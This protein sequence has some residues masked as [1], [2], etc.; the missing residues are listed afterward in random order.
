MQ[1]IH[2]LHIGKTGGS[3]LKNALKE[4]GIQLHPHETTLKSIPKGDKVIFS[5]RDPVD[6]FV[7]GFYSRKRQGAPRGHVPW[8]PEEAEAFG[9]FETPNALAHALRTKQPEAI[10]AMQSISHV[11]SSYWDWFEHEEYLQNRM[12]DILF[13][14]QQEHLDKDFEVLKR[15][16]DRPTLLLPT[17]DAGSHRSPEAEDRHL[18][19]ECYDTLQEWYKTDYEVLHLLQEHMER[20]RSHAGDHHYK[21][22]VGPPKQFDYMG[23]T[24]F[25]LLSALGLRAD[26]HVLDIGCGSLR[27]GRL[28]IPFLESGH[29]CGT[30]PYKWLI[31]DA[32]AHEIGQDMV[33]I[34][35]PR[36]D[37]SPNFNLTTFNQTFDFVLIQSIFS[38]A[39]KEQIDTALA[40]CKQVLAPTGIVAV[41][42]IEGDT[43]YEEADW[44]YPGCVQYTPRTIR[45]FASDAGLALTRTPWYHPR[46]TWYLLG[47]SDEHLPSVRTMHLLTGRTLHDPTSEK[48][49]PL[50]RRVLQRLHTIRKG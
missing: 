42:F 20:T 16:I 49:P 43:D 22:F 45:Q 15:I 40:A 41:T 7:S 11:N 35:T 50:H 29:Y 19:P 36:F 9:T 17:D 21:A 14:L 23:A 6:R 34:K 8:T 24:Q 47:H 2:L 27:A 28:L 12:D 37:H 31:D 26:H 32:I 3:A 33:R 13:V 39:S 5:V 25:R 48:T 30:D 10:E 38:H 46:Q 44:V 18:D 1:N 4:T